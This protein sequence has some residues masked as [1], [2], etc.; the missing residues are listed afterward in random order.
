MTSDR[1]H[2]V[3]SPHTFVQQPQ[4]WHFPALSSWVQCWLLVYC[5]TG[6]GKG[7]MGSCGE[8]CG[9]DPESGREWQVG[10]GRPG[11]RSQRRRGAVRVRLHDTQLVV[12]AAPLPPFK[13]PPPP[14]GQ[15][16]VG[17]FLNLASS[18]SWENGGLGQVKPLQ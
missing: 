12:P 17:R 7:R 14:A 2:E 10:D 15:A 6:P 18:V 1:C 16:T 5:G 9:E 4:A 11:P 3:L 13:P 8:A